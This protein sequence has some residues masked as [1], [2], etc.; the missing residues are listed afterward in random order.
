MTGGGLRSALVTGA[1]SGIGLACANELSRRG[2]RV[3]AGVRDGSVPEGLHVAATPMALDLTDSAQIVACV[4]ALQ[5]LSH[6]SFALV[7]SAGICTTAPLELLSGK[8]LAMMLSVNAVGVHEL[9]RAL[10]PLLRTGAGRVINI[11]STAATVPSPLNGGYAASKAALDALSDAMRLEFGRFGV[12]VTTV[13][14]GVVATPFWDKL[15]R[16]EQEFEASG[17]H[18][19]YASL[20]RSRQ[21]LLT[22][23]AAHGIPAERI[24][25]VIAHAIETKWPRRRYVVGR[26]AARRLMLFK[27]LPRP[28]FNVLSR[29][30]LPVAEVDS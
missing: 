7:N 11:S 16:R 2:Y 30:K 21:C 6:G 29:R 25:L 9:S 12:C 20:Y 17:D 4:Q 24:A 5:H 1:S 10:L 22:D 8:D 3:F 18:S 27:L 23:F 13:V 26:D 15:F 14:P 28:M 19:A